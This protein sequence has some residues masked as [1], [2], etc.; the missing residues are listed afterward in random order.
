M[1]FYGFRYSTS[2]S[3]LR[4]V[5]GPISI[6]GCRVPQMTTDPV[7][8]DTLPTSTEHG[9]LSN[10][11]K[12]FLSRKQLSEDVIRGDLKHRQK[13]HSSIVSGGITK[14][15]RQ[16]RSLRSFRGSNCETDIVPGP[17]FSRYVPQIYILIRIFLFI[18]NS[19]HI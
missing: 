14:H 18:R 17:G 8:C 9:Q 4:P 11:K 6:P 2:A 19:A 1:T 5:S 10:I 15:P 12:R 3:T 7:T 13:N 16:N